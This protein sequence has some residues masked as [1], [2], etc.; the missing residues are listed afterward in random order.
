MEKRHF[1]DD[2]KWVDPDH[3]C[4]HCGVDAPFPKYAGKPCPGCGMLQEANFA[5]VL[6]PKPV[7]EG[8]GNCTCALRPPE[9]IFF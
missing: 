1:D 8:C 9:E 7:C 2:G 5:I 3:K 4:L 6:G